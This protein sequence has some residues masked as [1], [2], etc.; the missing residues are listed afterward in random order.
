MNNHFLDVPDPGRGRVVNRSICRCRARVCSCDT[1]TRLLA[2]CDES[3]IASGISSRCATPQLLNDHRSDGDECL[4]TSNVGTNRRLEQSRYPVQSQY[5]Q[6]SAISRRILKCNR[7]IK[8]DTVR[9]TIFDSA[10]I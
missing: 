3:G 6:P 5:T 7:I 8:G 4:T 10:L 1:S 9:W 2:Y